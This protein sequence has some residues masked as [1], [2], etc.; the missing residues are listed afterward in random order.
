MSE[1]VE[2][3]LGE[4]ASM[5]WGYPDGH[6][7]IIVRFAWP[8]PSVTYS[9]DADDVR[10]ALEAFRLAAADYKNRRAGDGG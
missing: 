4:R 8:I 2:R 3:R 6:V 1:P 9:L 5:R 10:E 7:E